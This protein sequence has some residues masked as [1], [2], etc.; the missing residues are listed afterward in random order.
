[1]I[2][3][4]TPF[5]LPLFYPCLTWRIPT[6][7]KELYLTFDD[8]PVNGPTEFVL[9]ELSRAKAQA[10]FFCIG[11]NIRKHPAVFRQLLESDHTIGNHTFNHLNGWT[12]KTADYLHNV[13]RFE[14][15]VKNA[16]KHTK[17]TTLFRPP[18]GK[19]TRSQIRSLKR[20]NIIMWDVLSHDYNKNILAEVCLRKTIKATQKGS[21]LVFHD[22][23]KAEK[24]LV[25][26]LPRLIDHFAE[27]G[28]TFKAIAP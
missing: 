24:N 27:Q 21:I 8:G 22:S 28:Y 18:Y 5:F 17:T 23:F 20:Y 11:D 16:D 7:N 25:Y 26:V 14:E 19:I 3:Y 6:A 10:T 1:M 9:S 4:K 15:E 2:P 13:M 12:T